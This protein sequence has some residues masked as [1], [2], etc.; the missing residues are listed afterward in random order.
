MGETPQSCLDSHTGFHYRHRLWV[1]TQSDTEAYT[2]ALRGLHASEP[3]HMKASPGL[4][5][6]PGLLLLPSGLL[7]FMRC[8]I[9]GKCCCLPLL[10]A[11][12]PNPSQHLGLAPGRHANV[13][14]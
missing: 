12:L 3:L 10:E 4:T 2:H 6:L 5:Q 14:I 8:F 11:F 1:R 13:E 7:L 9:A